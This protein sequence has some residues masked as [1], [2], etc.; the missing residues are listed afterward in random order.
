MGSAKT[1]DMYHEYP[2]VFA[3]FMPCSALFPVKHNPFGLS[4]D[5]PGFNRTVAVPLFYSGGEAS[6]LP[7]LPFQNKDSQERVIY[8]AEVNDLKKDLN[9][10]YEDKDNWEDKI[11]GVPGDRVEKIPDE[12]RGSIL[13]VNYYDSKDGVCRTALASVSG[14]GHECRHHSCENAWKFISQFTK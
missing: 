10:P 2:E 5:D 6:P 7:E 9:V 4:Y 12:T 11:Y 1:W 14:Q 8:L 13:T 3:G